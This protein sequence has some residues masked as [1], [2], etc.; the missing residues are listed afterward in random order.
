[1]KHLALALACLWLW[2]AAAIAAPPLAAYAQLPATDLVTLSPSGDRI[3]LVTGTGD[4]RMVVV[5]GTADGQ[6]VKA[7]KIDDVKVRDL[8]WAGDE[9]LVVLTSVTRPRGLYVPGEWYAD[10]MFQ[11][12]ALNLQTKAAFVVFFHSRTLFPVVFSP[13]GYRELDGHWYGYFSGAAI[14]NVDFSTPRDIF[15]PVSLYQVDL[16]SGAFSRAGEGDRDWV[17]GSD[18]TPLVHADIIRDKGVNRW[19]LYAGRFE[20]DLMEEQDA[21]TGGPELM[22]LGRTADTYL[23]NRP[24]GPDV[25]LWERS[26]TPGQAPVNLARA[27][28]RSLLRDSAGRLIGMELEGDQPVALLFDPVFKASFEAVKQA[29][30]PA[31]VQPVSFSAS[32]KRV[33][34]RSVSTTEPGTFFL[35]DLATQNVT[36]IGTAYPDIKE[37]MIGETRVIHYRATDGLA[38]E[39][40]LTLPPGATAKSLPLIVLPHGGP[41]A[42]DYLDFDWIAQAFAGRGY[43]VFQPNFRGSGGF[44]TAFRDAGF[45][46]WGRK[47][48][49]DVSDGVSELARQGTID[50]RRVAIVG[51]SYGGYAA[52]AGVTIQHGLYRCAVSYGGVAD[53]PDM[54]EWESSRS[55][56][57]SPVTAYWRRYMGAKSNTD[58]ALTAFSPRAHA[59]DADAPVLLV[60]GADDTVVPPRQSEDMAK[61]LTAAGKPVELIKLPDE[62]HWL[63][64]GASRIATLQAAV[65][66]VEKYNPATVTH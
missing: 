25:G 55:G 65:D 31:W 34:V 12:T 58:S 24:S 40:V 23:V 56:E 66:F 53:L 13:A 10:E 11:A 42:R 22:G 29:F 5:R 47:M 45:G 43:A 20:R 2:S 33:I 27:P 7:L 60:Y 17:L 14:P 62:D 49:T 51:L 18:G 37:G 38:L 54:L 36:R 39:G 4:K 16:D 3:A 19:R 35:V 48:Q 9:H 26:L 1:M 6:I 50:P 30:L 8:Q 57:K 32:G 64:R 52:L 63:S 59:A 61:A 15:G 46:E 44:G 21:T 41:Q 28:V